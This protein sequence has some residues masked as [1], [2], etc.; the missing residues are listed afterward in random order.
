MLP[1]NHDLQINGY[2]IFHISEQAGINIFEPRPSPSHFEA[3]TGN[4]IF[5]ITGELLHNYLLPR[6]C[7]G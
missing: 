1:H 2:R 7:R 6:D 5:G 4:V 3:I